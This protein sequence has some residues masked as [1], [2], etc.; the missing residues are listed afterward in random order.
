ML[1]ENPQ[2]IREN[3]GILLEA[4]KQIGLEVNPEKTKFMIMSRDENIVR[5]ENIK[6]GNLSFEEVEK[7]KYLGETVTNINA[8]NVGRQDVHFGAHSSGQE[9]TV[10][11]QERIVENNHGY[12]N[13]KSRRL[14]WA[15]HVA[16]MG[17]SRNAYRVLVGRPEGKRSLGRPRRRWEDNIKM[18]LR[19][20]GYDDR[21]WINLAQDRDRWWAY[22]RAAINLQ[23]PIFTFLIKKKSLSRDLLINSVE[24]KS[25][26]SQRHAAELL[27]VPHLYLQR[28]LQS[29]QDNH[30]KSKGRQTTFTPEQENE[31][32][33]RI[34]KLYACTHVVLDYT[35]T[36][37]VG[38]EKK[39]VFVCGR[40]YSPQ[41]ERSRTIVI[42]S[43]AVTPKLQELHPR[44]YVVPAQQYQLCCFFIVISLTLIKTC[45]TGMGDAIRGHQRTC[46][47]WLLGLTQANKQQMLHVNSL[48]CFSFQAV[49]WP[50]L[51]AW[52]HL[53]TLLAAMISYQPYHHHHYHHYCCC[54]EKAMLI[55]L[56]PANEII[57]SPLGS[58]R[59]HLPP[60]NLLPPPDKVV[61]L[62][63]GQP[64]SSSTSSSRSF[65]LLAT[66][67][68]PASSLR[69]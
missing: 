7:F 64:S 28:R 36:Q 47:F 20:V 27:G 54:L 8:P 13:I 37:F 33:S 66:A 46:A 42:P 25:H 61:M 59:P 15:G 55:Y 44:P 67:V 32:V 24:V 5:N 65:S 10:D 30:L 53:A 50:L 18:D 63:S 69:L 52:Q 14:R 62:R 9:E 57:A 19:E 21:D 31:L 51:S 68:L 11:E 43:R 56:M 1:E 22:V 41:W 38:A 16:R 6:I 23:V 58:R 60:T 12:R 17:K 48:C 40:Y 39:T 34:L 49:C 45:S 3:T 4:S 26:L 35:A 29:G 2:T